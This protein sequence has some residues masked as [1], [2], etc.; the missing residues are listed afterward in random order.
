M[1]LNWGLGL[2]LRGFPPGGNNSRGLVPN[3]GNPYQ[4]R[5]ADPGFAAFNIG[6][7]RKRYI[8]G[9]RQLGLA[10]A[11]IIAEFIARK[12]G[13]PPFPGGPPGEDAR[14]LF[15]ENA[16]RWERWFNGRSPRTAAQYVD[17]IAGGAGFPWE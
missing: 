1:N 10:A 5:I 7:I 13:L 2:T 15:R 3:L 9:D 6:H 16:L 11:L 17:W 14:R 8:G 4:G 12:R